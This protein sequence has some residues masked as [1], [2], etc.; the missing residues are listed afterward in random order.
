MQSHV[1]KWGNSLGVRVPKT[2]A[3][4][5]G[6][7]AGTRVD[8]VTEDDRLVI[9]PVRSCYSLASLL[10]DT[11]PEAYAAQAV[12]WGPDRGREIVD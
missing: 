1:A 4:Q 11:T 9:R 3:D 12:D 8:I 2:L 7:A 6:L 10:T 5:I